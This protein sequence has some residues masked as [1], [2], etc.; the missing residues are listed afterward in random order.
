MIVIAI[1]DAA[2]PKRVGEE[3]QRRARGVINLAAHDLRVLVLPA[4]DMKPPKSAHLLRAALAHPAGAI[5][6]VGRTLARRWGIG[7]LSYLQPL[8]D[9]QPQIA[10]IPSM[11]PR[12]LYWRH[13]Q[14]LR[15]WRSYVRSLLP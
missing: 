6:I 7:Q 3:V 12:C 14:S 11:D 5:W 10:V 1:T 15:D 8:D 2:E 4:R 9:A 13:D